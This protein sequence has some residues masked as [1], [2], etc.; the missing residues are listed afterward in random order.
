MVSLSLFFS[1]INIGVAFIV[2]LIAWKN[3]HNR[4]Y[5]LFG[6]FSLFSGLYFL[7]R[8]STGFDII[9]ILF[10]AIYYSAFVLFIANFASIK[11]SIF[12]IILV[13]LFLIAF[14]LFALD[15]EGTSWQIVAHIGLLGI[16]M[17][18]IYASVKLYTSQGGSSLDFWIVSILFSLLAIEEISAVQFNT[19][20]FSQYFE[21]FQPLDIFP[22]LFTL[23]I[24]K[25]LAFEIYKKSQLEIELVEAQLREE[26]AKLQKSEKKRLE[27]ELLFKQ[28]DLTD[29]GLEIARNRAFLTELDKMLADRNQTTSE[30]GIQTIKSNIKSFL[31]NSDSLALLQ[32]NVQAVNHEFTAKLKSQFPDLTKNE[33][34]ICLLLRLQLSSKEIAAIKNISV[35][36]MKVLRYR[37]RK[38][39]G[40]PSN[41]SITDFILE[42]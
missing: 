2:F 7:A 4:S 32:K 37:L 42:L 25:R 6:V 5:L 27:T 15:N 36:S 16:M 40:L 17:Y 20:I 19:P 18:L 29:F 11:N 10:A 23:I 21:W 13:I 30:V 28:K 12:S 24:S 31:S 38:K 9:Y 14:V 41:K 22:I 34:R 39:L 35:D 1:G 8:S 26:R 3:G 33:V